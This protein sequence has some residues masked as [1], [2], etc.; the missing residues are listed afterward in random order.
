MF[1]PCQLFGATQSA[2]VITVQVPA[3]AQQTPIG[4]GQEL[5][6]QLTSAPSQKFSDAHDACSVIEQTPAGVQQAPC[7]SGHHPGVQVVPAPCHAFGSVHAAGVTTEQI[8]TG[9]QQA[10]SGCGHGFGVQIPDTAHDSAHWACSVTVQEPSAKQQAP[11]GISNPNPRQLTV[12][13]GALPV[14]MAQVLRPVESGRKRTV[15][16]LTCP[17]VREYPLAPE[18]SANSAQ[19]ADILPV[20][21]PAPSLRR[22]KERSAVW[23]STTRPKSRLS[24]SSRAKGAGLE[25]VSGSHPARIGAA[26]SRIGSQNARIWMPTTA[27][28]MVHPAFRIALLDGSRDGEVR[29]VRVPA[30]VPANLR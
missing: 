16:S 9:V 12:P 20:S 6:E 30:I 13:D 27:S 5:G 1:A 4:C 3:G 29:Q 26:M 19:E 22:V 18:T 2:R 14:V 25:T 11:V 8:P 10:P 23:P 21:V 17:A 7:G 15:T 28:F 24:G